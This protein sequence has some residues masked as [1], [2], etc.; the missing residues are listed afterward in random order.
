MLDV[1]LAETLVRHATKPDAGYLAHVT[2]RELAGWYRA[3]DVLPSGIETVSGAGSPLPEAVDRIMRD[4][5]LDGLPRRD[6]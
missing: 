1:P 5:G 2:G 3:R 4:T 6:L